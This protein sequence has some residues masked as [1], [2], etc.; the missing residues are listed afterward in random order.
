MTAFEARL[1]GAY[2]WIDKCRVL[3]P[4]IPFFGL[5]R[6]FLSFSSG[7]EVRRESHVLSECLQ[8]TL[9]SQE[10]QSGRREGRK[11]RET[12]A[13]SVIMTVWLPLPSAT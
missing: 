6:Q 12:V 3:C 2:I 5:E 9:K 4:L 1:R 10:E 7:L 11:F 13:Y 8:R